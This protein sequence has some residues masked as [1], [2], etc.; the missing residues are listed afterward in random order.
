[1]FKPRADFLLAGHMPMRKKGRQR[2]FG[3]DD[4]IATPVLRLPHLTNEPMDDLRPAFRF[5]NRPGLRRADSEVTG[6]GGSFVGFAEALGG[7]PIFIRQKSEGG[8]KENADLS[9]FRLP[10]SPFR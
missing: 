9:Y 4:E 3:I 8:S 2:D 6:H 7:E 10:T 5:R 1:M